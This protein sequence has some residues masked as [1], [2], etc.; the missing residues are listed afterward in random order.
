MTPRERFLK[1]AHGKTWQD[2]ADSAQFQAALDAALL[3]FTTVTLDMPATTEQ[4]A[5]NEWRRQ[6]A[7]SVLSTLQ[8]LTLANEPQK[9]TSTGE[10]QPT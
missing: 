8:N 4:A 9:R 3:Q 5:A 7:K 2:L 6:G 10:L 1:S